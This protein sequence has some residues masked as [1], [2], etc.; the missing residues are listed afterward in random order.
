MDAAAPAPPSPPRRHVVRH[1]KLSAGPTGTGARN[2]DRHHGI[3]D[4]GEPVR[5]G[6]RRHGDRRG[7]RLAGGLPRA[8]PV[9]HAACPGC[10]RAVRRLVG[11]RRRERRCPV[12]TPQAWLRVGGSSARVAESADARSRRRRPG[13]RR[14]FGSRRRE[15][16]CP[17]TAPQAWRSA[18]LRLASPRAEMPGH[19]AADRARVGSG[20]ESD[21]RAMRGQPILKRRTSHPRRAP[22]R[23]GSAA[24]TAGRP[25]RRFPCWPGRRRRRRDSRL[26]GPPAAPCPG[27]ACARPDCDARRA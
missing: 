19:G 10:G 11:S 20:S 21:D 1:F 5:E 14:L 23:R 15:R 16:R 6:A 18:A 17:I 12:T 13:G 7:V 24:R 4:R 3:S 25:G 9:L 27:R 2:G 22:G 26:A 8:R